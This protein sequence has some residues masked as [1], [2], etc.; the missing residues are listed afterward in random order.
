M[1]PKSILYGVSTT[2]RRT[3]QL[4]T[5]DQQG[6]RPAWNAGFSRHCGPPGPRNC[7]PVDRLPARPVASERPTPQR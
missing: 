4:R 6:T 5:A 3:G 1:V 7:V 2:D